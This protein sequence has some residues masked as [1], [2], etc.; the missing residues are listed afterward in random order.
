MAAVRDPVQTLRLA[1]CFLF[2]QVGGFFMARRP[3]PWFRKDR[4]AWFVTINGK[5]HNLGPDKKAAFDEFYRLMRQPATRKVSD[6]SLATI[7]DAF[8]DWNEK[9]RAPATYESYRYRLQRFVDRFPDLR[10]TQLRP[11]H[12]EQW[13]DSFPDLTKTSRRNYFRSVKRCMKWALQQGY[14]DENPVAHLEVPAAER[15]DTF[16]TSDQFARLLEFV[17]DDTF[18]ELLISV[19]DTGCRPQEILRVEARHVDSSNQ[20][21]VFPVAESKMKQFPRVVY[22][23]DRVQHISQRLSLAHPS[24]PLFRNTNGR[25]WTTFAVNCA[26]VRLQ[27]RM[28]KDE[29]ENRG[30]SISAEAITELVPQLSQTK[31]A[32]GK[33]VRKNAAE[34][35]CE[36]KRKLIHKRAAEL[37]P[38]YC[39]YALRHSWATKALQNGEDPLTVAILMGHKDPSMLAKVYQHLAHDPVYLLE[40]AKRAAS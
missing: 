10:P 13:V 38:K 31:R 40:K 27:M 18:R 21:W 36:A 30:E 39:L 9:N 2:T 12:V 11:F 32:K 24:G 8:L 33:T 35:R 3:K 37:A 20:R 34:L 22:L 4:G 15:R 16:V 28:G 26:F 14:V 25:P 19:W 5:R 17:R 29:I 7:I 1:W 23:T 6:D